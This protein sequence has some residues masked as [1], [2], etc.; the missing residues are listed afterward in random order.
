MKVLILYWGDDMSNNKYPVKAH[1]WTIKNDNEYEKV[2]DKSVFEHSGTGIPKTIRHYWDI[3]Q[4][5]IGES[6]EITL[7]YNDNRYLARLEHG[8]NGR[9]RLIWHSDFQ[10]ILKRFYLDFETRG[11]YGNQQDAAPV[12]LFRKLDWL[13]YEVDITD[14]LVEVPTE[15]I[16]EPE[17]VST[18][19]EEE[20]I[21]ESNGIQHLLRSIGQNYLTEK[22]NKFGGNTFGQFVRNEGKNIVQSVVSDPK[23]KVTV[24]VGQGQWSQIPWIGIFDR[25]LTDT[26]QKGY[27]LA[28]L[29]DSEMK[30]LYLTLMLGF[31]AF[32][33]RFRGREKYERAAIVAGNYRRRLSSDLGKYSLDKIDLKSKLVLAKG[34]EHCHICGIRYDVDNLPN[35]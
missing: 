11:V 29:Y 12:M 26:A 30:S 6:V 31:T 16:Q 8:Q 34:Y 32:N 3:E 17:L 33:E 19:Y 22:K 13:T 21:V 35:N 15:S 4:L 18:S 5:S 25:E 2:T 20:G 28:Y 10:S 24:S 9:T 27:Y 14:Q 7:I 1:S 23:Y